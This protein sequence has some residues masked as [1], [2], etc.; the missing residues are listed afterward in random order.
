MTQMRY[1]HNYGLTYR[2]ALRVNWQIEWMTLLHYVASVRDNVGIDSQFASL[3]R[4]HWMEAQ[5][6]KLDTLRVE[7]LAVVPQDLPD[8]W[9]A[10]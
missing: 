10:A 3:L 6:A 2:Q 9:H 1:N 5:H 7:A 4:H 8:L